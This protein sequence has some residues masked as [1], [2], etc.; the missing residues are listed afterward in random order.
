MKNMADTR[1]RLFSLSKKRLD[2][3]FMAIIFTMLR[4]TLKKVHV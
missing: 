3:F 2:A 4:K 1:Y